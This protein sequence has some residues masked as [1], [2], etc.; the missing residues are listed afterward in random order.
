MSGSYKT[1]QGPLAGVRV[2]EFASKGPGP[3]C[4]MLLSD[5]GADV[6][7]LD[8]MIPDEN[9]ANILAN[10]M[11]RGRRSVAIDLK[12]EAANAFVLELISKSDVLIEGMRPGAMERLGIGPNEAQTRNPKIIY[13]RMTGWGQIGPNAKLPGHDINYIATTGV[14]ASIGVPGGL[15]IPPLNLVGDYGGGLFL[16]F[17]I[18]SALFESTKS[19][20]GQVI[21]AAMIDASANMMTSFFGMMNTGQWSDNNRG[22]NILDGGA[23]FYACYKTADEKFI[24]IGTVENKFFKE[25][26]ARIGLPSSLTADQYDRTAWPKMREMIASAIR[27]K[28][29]DQWTQIFA[30]AETCLSPVMTL[31]EAPNDPHNH[32]RDTFIDI[33]GVIQPAPAPRFSRT[34]GSV[35]RPPRKVGEDTLIALT[36][37]GCC[38]TVINN[39]IDIG[40]LSVLSD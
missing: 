22:G 29:R 38:P 32:A 17:G 11:H 28:T 2:L 8:R 24:A 16:A 34:P 14:L 13:G 21:D 10:P 37:W 25:L 39:L 31:S 4:S 1:A 27:K 40:V 20:A 6:V 33:D 9:V 5:L 19:G 18:V 35:Q 7:R 15:P 30:G 12:H 23:P 3:Y 26:I 36:D